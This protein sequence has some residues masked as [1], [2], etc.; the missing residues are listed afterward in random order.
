MATVRLLREPAA[1]PSPLDR[2]TPHP[3]HATHASDTPTGGGGHGCPSSGQADTDT[4]DAAA[5][6]AAGL[7]PPPPPPHPTARR[8]VAEPRVLDQALVLRFDAPNSFTGEDV[9]E[10]HT[11]GGTAV[12]NGVLEALST[13]PGLRHAE[14]G[15]FTRRAFQNNKMDLTQV[16]GL[17]DLIN[18]ETEAQ[19]AQALR[20][21]SGQATKMYDQWRVEMYHCIAYIEAFIDFGEDEGIE[22]DAMAE[23]LQRLAVLRESM[24]D[25]VAE[26]DVGERLRHGVRIAIVGRPDVGKSSLLNLLCGRDAAIVAA[27]PGTTRDIVE[28]SAD[29]G[30]FPVVFQDTAGMRDGDGVGEVEREGIR[31]ARAAADDAD[32]RICV[33]DGGLLASSPDQVCSSVEGG[34]DACRCLHRPGAPT[35]LLVNKSDLLR[36]VGLPKAD[37]PGGHH[38]DEGDGGG[39][40]GEGGENDG[41]GAAEPRAAA[42]IAA[43]L[44]ISCSRGDGLDPFMAALT[45]Q[46]ERLCSSSAAVGPVIIQVRW[47]FGFGVVLVFVWFGFGGIH[48]SCHRV[49]ARGL[50]VPT[51][52]NT[53]YC[54]A[55]CS[56][57]EAAARRPVA[58]A[59]SFSRRDT[60]TTSATASRP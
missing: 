16:E 8:G 27:G 18:A 9:V 7:P 55:P 29:V 40:G 30:G 50:C 34:Q 52:E 10:L 11:H 24:R 59:T 48:C 43:Q 28:V 57:A 26:S 42:S 22:D 6:A 31:R 45:A 58:M 19:R 37:P 46:V 54:S 4:V 32:L 17:A 38:G 5:A 53:V 1:T 13:L 36:Q 60:G 25:Y 21:M 39:E 2:A 47:W 33:Q 35:L 23:S 14:P 12:V 15:E 49:M 41:G 20:Y 3:P 44:N 56:L 51:S